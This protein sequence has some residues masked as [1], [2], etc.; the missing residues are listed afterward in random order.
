MLVIV[1]C[2]KEVVH[3]GL[4]L[5]LIFGIQ[6]S[7]QKI[8][9]S[10]FL[11]YF[12]KKANF[13]VFCIIHTH[14][15]TKMIWS[16]AKLNNLMLCREDRKEILGSNSNYLLLKNRR[17]YFNFECGNFLYFSKKYQIQSTFINMFIKNIIL[18]F[19]K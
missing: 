10:I 17:Y 1:L 14:Y 9:F 11:D 8:F 19:V 12:T 16:F 15:R 2:P 7:L 6:I 5:H 3:H 18:F 4:C 13:A